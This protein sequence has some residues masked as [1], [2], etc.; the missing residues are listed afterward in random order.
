VVIE[1]VLVK[2]LERFNVLGAPRTVRAG[3]SLS[4]TVRLHLSHRKNRMEDSFSHLAPF[5]RR[6]AE[7]AFKMNQLIKCLD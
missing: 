3:F 2:G 7:P 4:L 6:G 1:I 5:R